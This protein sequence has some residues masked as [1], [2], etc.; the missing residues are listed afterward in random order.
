MNQLTPFK[1]DSHDLR[2]ISDEQG[3]LWFIAKEVAT[4]LEYSDSFEMTKRLDED[5][6]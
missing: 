5:E 4:I 1:F 3:E 2:I 6:K